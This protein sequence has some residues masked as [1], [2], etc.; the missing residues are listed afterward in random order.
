MYV[1]S[2]LVKYDSN[3][4]IMWAKTCSDGK[5]STSS[6]AIDSQGSSY[7]SGTSICPQIHFG[8]TFMNNSGS[9]DST[10]TKYDSNG[11]EVWGKMVGGASDEY[12][13][14]T[15]LDQNNNAFLLGSFMSNS[16]N[17]GIG[18]LNNAGTGSNS[19]QIF[20]SLIKTA[21]SDYFFVFLYILL[22]LFIILR[23]KCPF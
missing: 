22:L 19:N 12:G 21:S 5:Y 8:N 16:I 10:I 9:N 3:G 11:N 20:F 1:S 18:T 6:I 2:A 13:A 17:F 14:K 4:T 23:K 15:V 7:I